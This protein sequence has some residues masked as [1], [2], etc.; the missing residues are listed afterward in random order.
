MYMRSGVPNQGV[1]AVIGNHEFYG[2]GS[3]MGFDPNL[4]RCAPD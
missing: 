2:G 4:V 3:N 1:W